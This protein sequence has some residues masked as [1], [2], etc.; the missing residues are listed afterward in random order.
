[1]TTR[2]LHELEATEFLI[3]CLIWAVITL[4]TLIRL[5]S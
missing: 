1:M 4:S 3:E 5:I 2:E